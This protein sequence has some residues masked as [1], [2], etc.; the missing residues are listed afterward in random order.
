LEPSADLKPEAIVKG[1]LQ[2]LKNNNSPREDAGLKA[3]QR[4]ST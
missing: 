1:I 3:L 4:F 2:A